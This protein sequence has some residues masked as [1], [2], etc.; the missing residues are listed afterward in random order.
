MWM[1]WHHQLGL[2]ALPGKTWT[3][4][5]GVMVLFVLPS[6]MFEL[7]HDFVQL[8]G[9]ERFLSQQ[10]SASQQTSVGPQFF[11]RLAELIT[12]TNQWWSI[13][14]YRDMPSL[15]VACD[16]LLKPVSGV[17]FGASGIAITGW[18]LVRLGY[19]KLV[20][21]LGLALSIY[22][23][24]YLGYPGSV[25]MY[26]LLAVSPFLILGSWYRIG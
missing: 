2:R 26:Y 13:G 23:I 7:S 16:Q 11:D 5:L 10:F 15:L 19:I 22:A 12:I 18:A 4:C 1:L 24:F 25:S 21:L 6:L 8:K 3:L 14:W 20:W 17:I 9:L